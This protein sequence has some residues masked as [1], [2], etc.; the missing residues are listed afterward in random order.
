MVLRGPGWTLDGMDGFSRST[1]EPGKMSG[2]LCVRNHR[3][4]MQHLLTLAGVRLDA[5]VVPG[6]LSNHQGR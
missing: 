6:R 1:I 4:T 2:Q 3:F 5:G